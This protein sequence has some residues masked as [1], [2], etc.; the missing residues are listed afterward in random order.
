MKWV[1][2]VTLALAP[3]YTMEHQRFEFKDEATC[4]QALQAMIDKVNY[5]N[6][7]LIIIGRCVRIDAQK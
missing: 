4:K 3:G 5:H 6:A 7:G 1:L 2:L